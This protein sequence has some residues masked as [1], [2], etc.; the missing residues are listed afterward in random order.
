VQACW[1][2]AS[3]QYLVLVRGT[4]ELAFTVCRPLTDRGTKKKEAPE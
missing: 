1:Q 3:K 4:T 2:Q